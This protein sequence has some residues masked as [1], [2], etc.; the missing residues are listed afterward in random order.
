M[1]KLNEYYN[2]SFGEWLSMWMDTIMLIKDEHTMV[3][4]SDNNFHME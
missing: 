3:I 1:V 4:D 2:M